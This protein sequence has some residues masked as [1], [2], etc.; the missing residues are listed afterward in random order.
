M[1]LFNSSMKL[2]RKALI[3]IH[4]I[5][6][7]ILIILALFAFD[8]IGSMPLSDLWSPD[9]ESI[10]ARYGNFEPYELNQMEIR[11]FVQT[12]S[13]IRVGLP[14]LRRRIFASRAY[15]IYT[16]KTNKRE[17]TFR[18]ECDGRTGDNYARSYLAYVI[19]DGTRYNCYDRTLIRELF[20]MGDQHIRTMEAAE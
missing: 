11:E 18:I 15:P 2:T 13:Y 8:R 17:Y 7:A 4:C 14:V 3:V 20:K 6:A 16:I 19:I 1:K 5:A 12:L 9:V 10:T